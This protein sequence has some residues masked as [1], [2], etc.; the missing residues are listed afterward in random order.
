MEPRAGSIAFFFL[1]LLLTTPCFSQG[2][3]EVSKVDSEVYEIDYK[4]PETHSHNPPPSQSH[5]KLS[6]HQEGTVVHRKSKGLGAPNRRNG[7]NH[8]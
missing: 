1:V 3:L 6:A 5:H 8:G 7:N 4:G 2:G